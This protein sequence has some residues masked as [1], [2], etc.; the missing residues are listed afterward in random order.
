MRRDRRYG[1]S[2]MDD[3]PQDEEHEDTQK[4]KF[5]TFHLGREDYG[6]EISYVTEIIGIQRITEVV[7]IPE[8]H[9]EP[10]PRTFGDGENFVRGMGKIGE[11]VQILLDVNRLLYLEALDQLEPTT[12]A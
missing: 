7:D 10:L 3:A 11:K 12:T 5:L 9:I 6:I 2:G 1:T 8:K 4:G